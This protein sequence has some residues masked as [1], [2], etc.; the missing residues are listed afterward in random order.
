M[1]LLF[2]FPFPSV[3]IAVEYR[4]PLFSSHRVYVVKSF[5]GNCQITLIGKVKQ[6]GGNIRVSIPF[7]HN[8]FF[9]KMQVSSNTLPF[10]TYTAIGYDVNGAE[11]MLSLLNMRNVNSQVI[12]Y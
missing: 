10:T 4:A 3:E 11:K 8:G 1:I 5:S 9:V 2:I 12:M 6:T 7:F